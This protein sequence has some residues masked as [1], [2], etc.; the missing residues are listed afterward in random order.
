MIPTC[1]RLGGQ[2]ILGGDMSG[3]KL[4]G[5]VSNVSSILRELETL[6]MRIEIGDDFTEYRLIRNA[7]GDRARL[8]PMFDAS[9]SYVDGTNAFWVCGYN[10]D[11][12]LVHTQ[13]MRLFDIGDTT[14]KHHLDVHR[15]KYITPD[16]TPDPDLTFFSLP[17]SLHKIS[18][19]VAY[20][21]DFWVHSRGLGGPRSQMMTP[22]LSRIIF[23]ICHKT[24]DPDFVFALVPK[25]LAAKGAHLRYGYTHC[26]P[27]VWTG[28]DDQITDEDWLIWMSSKDVANMLE[29]RIPSL[30]KQQSFATISSASKTVDL[31]G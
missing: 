11:D 22:L 2:S 4:F 20:H 8:Y 6:G 7:Q 12:Q 15:H 5:M 25:Q 17:R 13:A 9:S 28:P 21:G 29:M 30:Q 18:G 16:T 26:E 1:V 31:K 10:Q 3:R 19:R 27:G 24:W 14:L 23:E